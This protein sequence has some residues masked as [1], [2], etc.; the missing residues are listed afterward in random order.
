MCN[1]FSSNTTTPQKEVSVQGG[2]DKSISNTYSNRYFFLDLAKGVAII[3]MLYGHCIQYCCAGSEV[4]FFENIVFK[5]IY[6]FHMPLFMLISG[7]LFYFSFRKRDL[8]ELLIHRVQSLVQPIIFGGLFMFLITD[9]PIAIIKGK[10]SNLFSG[11][12]FYEGSAIW[13]LWSV[14]A[15]SVVVAVICKRVNGA[16]RQ[17]ILL[18]LATIVVAFFP[19]S[20]VNIFMYPYFILGFFFAKN[21][22]NIPRWLYKSRYSS[23]VLFPLMLCLY[24]KKHYIYTTGIYSDKYS[25]GEIIGIDLYRWL[26]GL[27]G[28]IFVLTLLNLVYKRHIC[29]ANKHLIS[30]MLAKIGSKSLQMYIISIPL[31]STYLYIGFPKILEIFGAENLLV[32]NM[33][34]YNF[35]FTPLLTIVYS[36]GL[37]GVLKLLEKAKISKIMFGR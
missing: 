12:W 17:L 33:F 34:I 1:I 6:S 25:L 2:I 24:E 23:L 8:K 26:I 27:V 32:R 35:I 21:K 5:T 13:F 22:E 3:L 16:W 37:Y 31:L 4:D 11:G 9:G 7:Y 14:L 36:F 18:L 19:N 29:K 20:T 10:F 30:T 28:S 15:A